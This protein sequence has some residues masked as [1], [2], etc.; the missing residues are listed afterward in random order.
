MR[1]CPCLPFFIL[2]DLSNK[3]MLS[4]GGMDIARVVVVGEV[5]TGLIGGE[6]CICICKWFCNAQKHKWCVWVY[7][8]MQ[9]VNE[10]NNDPRGGLQIMFVLKS[11]LHLP[12]WQVMWTAAATV[13][14][15]VIAIGYVPKYH[16]LVSWLKGWWWWFFRPRQGWL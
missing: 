5:G 7:I 9:Y 1:P 8:W 6:V 13:E 14:N 10:P 16:C 3:L 12:G 11:H 15:D 4:S 2:T